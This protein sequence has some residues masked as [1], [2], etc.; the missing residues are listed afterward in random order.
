MSKKK[1][2][3]LGGLETIATEVVENNNEFVTVGNVNYSDFEW[4]QTTTPF[5]PV[6]TTSA[7]CKLDREPKICEGLKSLSELMPNLSKT[8]IELGR[9]WEN[10]VARKEIKR[11]LDAEAAENNFD[12]VYYM[13]NVLRGEVEKLENIQEAINR[14]LYATTY[15]KPREGSKQAMKQIKI[16]GELFELSERRFN[17]LRMQFIDDKDALREAVLEEATKVVSKQIEE[18]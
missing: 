14:L 16:G 8:F 13:Q 3:V 12:S 7:K 4:L 11:M 1:D 17:E 2:L 5:F 18:L 10:K 6:D 9:W 15:Y